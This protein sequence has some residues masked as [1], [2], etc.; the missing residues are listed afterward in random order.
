V[1]VCT[2]GNWKSTNYTDIELLLN[3]L[4]NKTFSVNFYDYQIKEESAIPEWVKKGNIC[5]FE[6]ILYRISYINSNNT[7]TL[8]N[9]N[10][11][12]HGIKISELTKAV[13][14]PLDGSNIIAHCGG[15]E[16]I[17][18]GIIGE[19]IVIGKAQV[20]V[21]FNDN[22]KNKRYHYAYLAEHGTTLSGKP[23][24][25]WKPESEVSE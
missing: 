24:C 11:S 8:S 22:N 23:L 17:I 3:D 12:C 10:T 18:D 25:T 4:K 15:W 6:N 2:G 1:K 19:I 21:Y 13:K 9:D 20:E 7:V 14:S 5:F 16:L